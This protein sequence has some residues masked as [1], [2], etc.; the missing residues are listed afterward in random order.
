MTKHAHK[1]YA[2]MRREQ[3]KPRLRF[4]VLAL[5]VFV[6][7]IAAG[8]H[9]YHPGSGYFS[10]VS[11]VMG[12]MPGSDLLVENTGNNMPPVHFEFYT[13]LP[14]TRMGNDHPLAANTVKQVSPKIQIADHDELERQLS[15]VVNQKKE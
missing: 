5:V 12:R 9:F 10:K 1:R 15:E 8:V 11:G 2:S 13:T 3:E 6:L 7:A 4:A 14:K